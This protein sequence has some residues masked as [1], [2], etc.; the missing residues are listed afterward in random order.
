VTGEEVEQLVRT[1]IGCWNRADWPGYRALAGPGYVYEEAGTGR[2]VEDAEAVLA[3]WGRLKTAFPDATAEIVQTRVER[4]VTVV[5]VIWR[6][7]QP[8]RCTPPPVS[9]RRRTRR[10]RCGT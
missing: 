9:S 6:P 4:D 2:R 5:G 1:V 8:G 3:G 10:S 7:P